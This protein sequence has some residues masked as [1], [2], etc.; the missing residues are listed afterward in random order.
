MSG[1]DLVADLQQRTACM[2]LAA[3]GC[4]D[5]CG[6]PYHDRCW[7]VDV[8][9]ADHFPSSIRCAVQ[10]LPTSLRTGKDSLVLTL[11]LEFRSEA[12]SGT[13]QHSHH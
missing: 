8:L 13:S 9:F 12:Q 4:V 7:R 6:L 2:S 3:V 11:V 10:L 5:A 1:N